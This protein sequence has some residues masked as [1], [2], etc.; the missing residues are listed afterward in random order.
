MGILIP[1]HI[2]LVNDMQPP[3]DVESSVVKE[4]AMSEQNRKLIEGQN[5]ITPPIKPK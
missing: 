5:P 3:I 4:D 2:D 1:P